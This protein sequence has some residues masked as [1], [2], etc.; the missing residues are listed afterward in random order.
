MA[1]L[2]ATFGAIAVMIATNLYLDWSFLQI[3]GVIFVLVAVDTADETGPVWR[4][5]LLVG[6]AFSLMVLAHFVV[7]DGVMYLG[8]LIA[9]CVLFMIS[10]YSLVYLF[11]AEGGAG[12]TLTFAFISFIFFFPIAIYVLYIGMSG[13]GYW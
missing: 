3:M 10:I 12:S 9:S 4:K 5:R 2:I 13:L 7:A 1:K 8:A 11:N 6:F